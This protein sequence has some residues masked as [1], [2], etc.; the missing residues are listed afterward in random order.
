MAPWLFYRVECYEELNHWT[1]SRGVAP[2]WRGKQGKHASQVWSE[3]G[4]KPA[5]LGV[6]GLH[7]D[8]ADWERGGGGRNGLQVSRRM[9][10]QGFL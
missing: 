3:A 1:K 2:Y 5:V 9:G 6:A 8:D 7:H 10:Y 4:C